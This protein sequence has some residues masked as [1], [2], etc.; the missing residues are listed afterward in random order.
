MLTLT[1]KDHE[2][3]KTHCTHLKN[4]N[5]NKNIAYI[6]M[7]RAGITDKNKVKVQLMVK[8][9]GTISNS[10]FHLNN[11]YHIFVLV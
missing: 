1:K 5:I 7:Y 8:F 11:K 4:K 9:V 6:V 2:P 10:D 3:F